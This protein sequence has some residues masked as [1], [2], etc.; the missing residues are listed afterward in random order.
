VGKEKGKRKVF[1]FFL[2]D[3]LAFDLFGFLFS[4][5]SKGART[6]ATPVATLFVY[7]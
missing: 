1:F 4:F 6:A 2:L 5:V 3:P 7:S